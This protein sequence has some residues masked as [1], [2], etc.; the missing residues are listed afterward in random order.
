MQMNIKALAFTFALAWA[1]AIFVTG[2]ANLIW[3][4]YGGAFLET[5]T[6]VY[7]GYHGT[8]SLTQ[9]I[10][11]TLYGLLDGFIGGLVVGWLYNLFACRNTAT[12]E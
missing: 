10:V 1:G 4:G 9:L 2:L 11:G 5:V 3:P 12:S 7:P 6:S 8:G